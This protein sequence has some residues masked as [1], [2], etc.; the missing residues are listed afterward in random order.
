MI[1]ICTEQL[2][3]L[4]AADTGDERLPAP[5]ARYNRLALHAGEAYRAAIKSARDDRSA[6]IKSAREAAAKGEALAQ[7]A[8]RRL[9]ARIQE[10]VTLQ[11]HSRATIEEQE[12]LVAMRSRLE[13]VQEDVRAVHDALYAKRERAVAAAKAIHDQ[14]VIEARSA[15]SVAVEAAERAV[16]AQEDA[17]LEENEQ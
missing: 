1:S 7:N 12:E 5:A 13:L 10:L 15:L 2:G 4:A 14:R 16:T 6:S 9:R 17:Q 8:L 3:A 11:E